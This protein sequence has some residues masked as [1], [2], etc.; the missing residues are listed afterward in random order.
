MSSSFISLSNNHIIKRLNLGYGLVF[1]NNTWDLRYYEQFADA[2][3]V[4][5]PVKKNYNS[6]GLIFPINYEISKRLFVG[7]TYRPT[8]YRFSLEDHFVYEHTLSLNFG[9]K[10]RLKK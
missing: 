8:F 6:L 3:P 9:W 7:V 10:I 2:P 1:A 4:R 5:E